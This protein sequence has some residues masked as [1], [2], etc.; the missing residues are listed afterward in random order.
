MKDVT[1]GGGAG[2]R[3]G[4]FKPPYFFPFFPPSFFFSPPASGSAFG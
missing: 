2:R 1:V 4:T 3:D